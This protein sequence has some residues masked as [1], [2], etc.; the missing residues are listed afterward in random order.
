MKSFL[1]WFFDKLFSDPLNERICLTVMGFVC[2]YFL[3]HFIV[4]FFTTI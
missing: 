4:S 3:I 2:G 1:Y